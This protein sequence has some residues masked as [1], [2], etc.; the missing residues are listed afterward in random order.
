MTWTNLWHYSLQTGLL[1]GAAPLLF[2][3]LRMRDP[4]VRLLC[5]QGVLIAC[6]ALPLVQ[7]QKKVIQ[8]GPSRGP[9]I[10][11]PASPKGSF[12]V[13]P[14][15]VWVLGAS[16]LIVRM[17]LGMWRLRRLRVDSVFHSMEDGVPVRTSN[18]VSSPVA[19]GFLDPVILLP[20]PTLS[21]APNL[22]RAMIAHEIAHVR[23]KDWIFI[24]G[25]EA[26][27]AALWFHPA[28]W[29]LLAQIRLAR[30][31]AVDQQ[32]AEATDPA[33][34]VEALLSV[35]GLRTRP[36]PFLV[37]PF[38]VR[39]MS[40][41]SSLE[42]RLQALNKEVRMSR[43]HRLGSMTVSAAVALGLMLASSA[44]FPLL[45]ESTPPKIIKKQDPVYPPD[46]KDEK[47]EGTVL[48]KC[49]IGKEGKVTSANVVRG[50]SRLGVAAV[51]SVMTWEFQPATK[52]GKPVDTQANIEVNFKLK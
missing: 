28:V 35:A 46:A 9:A 49:V 27:R 16:V 2:W 13:S 23:R 25:E 36:I 5:L 38:L 44:A 12:I 50:E 42:R 14:E 51:E 24:L 43:I 52:D 45:A 3:I 32:V 20:D 17:A 4:K 7:P 40:S 19:F 21:L 22:R 26:A 47:V 39:M 11:A 18:A 1:I 15:T 29:W 8:P 34:Y 30:E 31:Q 6:L 10:A 33:Q 37:S 41:R 48:L